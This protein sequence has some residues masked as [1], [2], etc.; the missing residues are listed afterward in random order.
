MIRRRH[1]PPSAPT[2]ALQPQASPPPSSIIIVSGLTPTPPTP[3]MRSSS[4]SSYSYSSSSNSTCLVWVVRP[5][6]VC[7]REK[8][9]TRTTISSESTSH[10]CYIAPR[11]AWKD[12]SGPIP[13]ALRGKF[14]KRMR[15]GLQT[16]SSS[17]STASNESWH[18]TSSSSCKSMTTTSSSA[19]EPG[20]ATSTLSSWKTS[21]T[22]T[23]KCLCKNSNSTWSSS[24]ISERTELLLRFVLC[25]CEREWLSY[26]NR[27]CISKS[28]STVKTA[29]MP[30]WQQ[31]VSHCYHLT[32]LEVC[33]R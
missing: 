10:S 3:T 29:C 16:W 5:W 28:P 21:T 33:D 14:R 17:V 2:S 15:G 31:H 26:K 9:R 27:I 1:H 22:Q 7:G 25:M 6:L 23:S 4:S 13:S 18:H 20:L 12:H 32:K 8:P 11:E 24:G 30:S 19:A